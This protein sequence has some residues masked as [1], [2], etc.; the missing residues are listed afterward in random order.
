MKP[1][2]A[3]LGSHYDARFVWLALGQLGGAS[4]GQE[5]QLVE[6]L[7]TIFGKG[8]TR[9]LYKGRDAIEYGLRAL[10]VGG[11]DG[12]LL[13]A[14]TCCAVEEGIRRA[15]ATPV[16]AD[17]E[18]N[19]LHP[20]V[21]TLEKAY[22]RSPGVK[23]VLIQHTLGY[24]APVRAIR[25][26]CEKRRLFLIEDLAQAFGA[27]DED[28]Q[29]LGTTSGAIVLSFGRD[30]IVDAIAGGA[31]IVRVT[32][33]KLPIVNGELRKTIIAKDMMYPL[34]TSIIRNTYTLGFGK[35]LH[36]VLKSLGV[37]GSPTISP[38]KH[39]SPLPAAYGCLVLHQ[40]HR[41]EQDIVRRRTIARV[42]QAELGK[43]SLVSDDE[44][45]RGVC[46]RY[47]LAVSNPQ[48][49]VQRLREKNVF[50]AD[51]WYRAAVDCGSPRFG[52]AGSPTYESKYV[53]KSCPR[54]EALAQ[55]IVNL[56]TH[57][58][59]SVEMAQKISTWVREEI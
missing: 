42:Y 38:T 5:L 20:S 33:D 12:V 3:S 7:T 31:A 52:E 23:A 44:I 22:K 46:L 39:M 4:R 32:N 14:F 8:E 59:T 57:R 43:S 18:K 55:S 30:K 1:L 51:R 34:L 16:F 50:V 40:L 56:P 19:S 54:A 53:G 36:A 11:G 58:Q 17:I 25:Q 35:G 15:E 48:K 29:R 49:I 47:P 28:G 13:Q 27:V 26:W 6:R 24:P 21:E 10:G 45:E 37:L 2:F 9:L 41:L